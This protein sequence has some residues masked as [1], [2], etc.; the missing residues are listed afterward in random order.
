[1]GLFKKN[2]HAVPNR[3]A[4]P[5]RRPVQSA[6]QWVESLK[7]HGAATPEG[8]A[9]SA[10]VDKALARNAWEINQSKMRAAGDAAWKAKYDKPEPKKQESG[11]WVHAEG[12]R[13]ISTERM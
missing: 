5:A 4:S 12:G 8:K 1:M 3:A 2:P 6:D 13:A 7:H 9:R 10:A 11:S